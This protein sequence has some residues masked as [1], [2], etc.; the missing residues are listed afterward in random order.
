MT[1]TALFEAIQPGETYTITVRS[2]NPLMGTVYGS[3][4]YPVN[5]IINIGASPNQGFYFSGWQDGDMNNPR[6]ITVTG[7]AEYVA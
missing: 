6:T 2:E 4:T 1:F 5:T 3:G 7:D